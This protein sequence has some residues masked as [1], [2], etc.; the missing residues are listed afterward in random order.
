MPVNARHRVQQGN[1]MNASGGRG[2][3]EKPFEKGFFSLPPDPHP[4]FPQL[5]IKETAAR[6]STE[7]V[8]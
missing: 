7:Y 2:K 3:G 4:S 6:G 8:P 1:R 5:F